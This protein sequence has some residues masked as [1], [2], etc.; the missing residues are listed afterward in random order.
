VTPNRLAKILQA[1]NIRGVLVIG[2]DLGRVIRDDLDPIW[3]QSAAIIMG[4]RPLHPQLSFASND[5]FSTTVQA[6]RQILELGYE[7][8]GLCL[9]SLV[10]DWVERRFSGGFH[11]CREL[12]RPENCIPGF[13][14]LP[15][16]EARFKAWVKQ[17]RPDVIVTVHIEI[18]A[19]VKSMGLRVPEDIGIV[20]LD[21][22]PEMEW[23]GMEQHNRDVGRAAVDMLIGQLHRNEY[24]V[25][26]FQKGTFVT[27]SWIFGPTVRKQDR[28][29]SKSSIPA[30]GRKRGVSKAL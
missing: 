2:S 3:K 20:H 12:L 21:K 9:M 25:P 10:N 30:T 6:I 29:N 28:S 4:V 1:R 19:W 11:A 16:A 5:Q 18:L 13:A 17:H 15:D 7:R 23:A 22:T 26:P 14:F 24:G 27:S 8:P